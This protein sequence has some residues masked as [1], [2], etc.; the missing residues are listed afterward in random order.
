L[1][2]DAQEPGMEKSYSAANRTAKILG[3]R[4]WEK[5]GDVDLADRVSEGLP[6]RS[7][8]DAFESVSLNNPRYMHLVIPKSSLAKKQSEKRLSKAQSERL[9]SVSRVFSEALRL[10]KADADKARRFLETPHP[11]IAGRTPLDLAS[12]SNA[13]A[14][15]VLRLLEKAEAGVSV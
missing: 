3:L 4:N 15:A 11:L 7:V 9:V 14:D 6:T 12:G 5:I 10:Y 1:G 8:Q 2:H 13:G